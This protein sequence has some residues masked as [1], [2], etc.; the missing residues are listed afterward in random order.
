MK[1]S[2]KTLR[3]GVLLTLLTGL[4]TLWVVSVVQVK[5]LER[6][7]NRVAQE[8]MQEFAPGAGE[9]HDTASVVTAWRDYLLLG[10]VK[11]K[12]EVFIRQPAPGKGDDP[13]IGGVTYDFEK[14][15]DKWIEVQS[16]SV[17][18]SAEHQLRGRS[19]FEAKE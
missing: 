2:A 6:D 3:L 4:A 1:P 5:A 7:L 11:G 17:C 15:G 13:Q 10:P 18:S 19:A 8:K 12:V 16:G 9:T 14:R